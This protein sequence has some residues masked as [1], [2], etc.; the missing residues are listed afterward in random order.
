M[1]ASTFVSQYHSFLVGRERKR[2]GVPYPNSYAAHAEAATD[3]AK[4][5]FNC[6]QRAHAHFLEHLPT[7][8]IASAICGL[9]Y[10]VATAALGAAWNLSRIV[11][12]RG[13]IASTLDQKGSGRYKGIWYVPVELGLLVTAGY[14]IWK[15][16]A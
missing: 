8:V 14:T 15:M 16:L 1:L 3:L 5:R 11:Y 2:A 6:A 12:A 4:Y 9:R 13:Y 7:F 10:P